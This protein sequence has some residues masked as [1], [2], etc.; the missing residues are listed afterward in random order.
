MMTTRWKVLCV[1]LLAL[2]FCSGTPSDGQQ[3]GK[4][5]DK[6]TGKKSDPGAAKQAE[7]KSAPQSEKK[8]VPVPAAKADLPADKN[9]ETVVK[10]LAALAKALNA[11]DPEA[12]AKQFTPG[13]EFIDADDNVFDS[14]EAIAGEFK[15]LFEVNPKK[16]S[17]ELTFD[18]IREISPGILSVDCTATYSDTE[19]KV[20]DREIVDVD[21]SAL[22]VKQA[23]GSWLFASIRSE[24]EGNDT[25]PHGQLKRLEWLI[26][27]WVDESDESTIH[28]TTRW[29]D[30]GNFLL[31]EFTIHVAGRKV[32]TGTQRIGWDGSLDKFKSWVFDSEGGHA[33]GIWTEIEGT[34]VVKVMGVRPDGDACSATNMYEHVRDDTYLFSVTDRV[35]GDDTAPDFTV[36]VVRK[37][38][39][40]EKTT[41]AISPAGRN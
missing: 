18:E 16:D 41:A 29:S 7:K 23:N 15:V 4:S 30:D 2:A 36:K 20:E 25:T 1:S 39:E 33:E 11:R 37:P 24:G 40:P 22:L 31:T 10:A 8:A 27:E 32:M 19:G 21:F 35:I 3:T 13:G 28:T 38:P 14:H 34:W 6:N 5:T 9:V 26:G 17:V 12:I